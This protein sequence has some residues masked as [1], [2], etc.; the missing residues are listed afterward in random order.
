[1]RGVIAT[2]DIEASPI[3]DR[4]RTEQERERLRQLEAD[5]AHVNRVTMLGELAASLSHELKQPITAAITNAKTC[6]LWLERDQPDIEEAS[7]A[8]A[9][10]VKDGY[11]A[12]E[13]INCLRSFYT[14]GAPAE[15]E[16][17]DL[18]VLVREM[19]ILLRSEANRHSIPMRTDLATDLP[20][21]TADR[22]QCSRCF[23]IS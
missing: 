21:V 18:N 13:I 16:V 14:R 6:L 10:I 5:L 15:R 12:V 7:E 2:Q 11:R 23:S 22:V 3:E 9:R 1:M 8:V 17:V 20:R 19:I 4:K